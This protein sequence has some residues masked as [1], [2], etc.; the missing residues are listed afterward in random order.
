LLPGDRV[1]SCKKGNSWFRVTNTTYP[2]SPHRKYFIEDYK[3]T[4]KLYFKG[5][6]N[7]DFP[8]PVIGH[9]L[10]FMSGYFLP[11]Y[12]EKVKFTVKNAS[13]IAYFSALIPH[14]VNPDQIKQYIGKHGIV[15]AA[16]ADGA[17]VVM[18]ENRARILV[19]ALT[20]TPYTGTVR[21]KEK[22][23]KKKKKKK[24]EPKRKCIFYRDGRGKL[25]FDT[26]VV[27]PKMKKKRS[28]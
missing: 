24:S 10:E 19:P 9:I 15:E 12:G 17:A 7:F 21:I 28:G 4:K 23:K 5:L 22:K 27:P 3:K 25:R 8:L 16:Y 18:F 1:T 2:E 26:V 13:E 20:L 14:S 6:V 11:E